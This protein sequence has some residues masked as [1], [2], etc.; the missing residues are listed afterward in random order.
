MMLVCR[1]RG[2]PG[3][4]L[5]IEPRTARGFGDHPVYMGA[6]CHT[7]GRPLTVPSRDTV[8]RKII[9]ETPVRMDAR[10]AV[11][12]A[13]LLRDLISDVEQADACQRREAEA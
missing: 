12:L 2:Y 1:V 3:V 10:T 11:G 13:S 8:G 9:V 5:A 6:S 4:R 7:D